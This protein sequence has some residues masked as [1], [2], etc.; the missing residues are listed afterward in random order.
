M[1]SIPGRSAG[2]ATQ[3]AFE[4]LAPHRMLEL[5]H[6][7]GLD[8]PHAFSRDFEDSPDLLQRVGVPVTQPVPKPDNLTFP[9]GEGLEKSL[10][11][12]SLRMPLLAFLM[13]LSLV[14]S[15]TNSP[16][17]QSSLSPTG[18]SRLTGCRPMSRTRRASSIERPARSATSS[19]VG[20]RRNSCK[21]VFCILRNRD[22]TSIIC[23]GM[24]MVLAG[25]RWPE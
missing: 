9:I 1:E 24:R 3:E 4:L 22:K 17:E 7:L 14:W 16:K 25:P 19:V 21:R 13:G 23:T 18:R 12:L 5:S 11:F 20:S 15:S 8:L 10:N 6:G 2:H